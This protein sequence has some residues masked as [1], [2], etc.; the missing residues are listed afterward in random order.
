M[1]NLQIQIPI[2]TLIVKGLLTLI[3]NVYA[4]LVKNDLNHL[5]INDLVKWN[6]Y[7]RELLKSPNKN[8]NERKKNLVISWKIMD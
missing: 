4:I 2:L 5:L 3:F 7:F 6:D 8:L 1:V